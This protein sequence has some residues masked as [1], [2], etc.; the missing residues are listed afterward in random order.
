MSAASKRWITPACQKSMLALTVADRVAVILRL[1]K[2]DYQG[3]AVVLDLAHK[4][5]V[6]DIVLVVNPTPLNY[7]PQQVAGEVE[8]TYQRPVVSVLP[9]TDELM[10]LGGEGLF[11]LRHPTHPLTKLISLLAAKLAAT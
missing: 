3:T 1:D 7:A 8:K 9:V 4:L 6:P 2:Q 11:V 5:E 10:S